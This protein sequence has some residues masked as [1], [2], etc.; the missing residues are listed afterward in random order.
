MQFTE[1]YS[2]NVVTGC[3]RPPTNSR[4]KNCGY[5]SNLEQT[6][7][8]YRIRITHPLLLWNANSSSVRHAYFTACL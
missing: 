7:T 5:N 1:V 4:A 6:Q 2:K 3:A 8:W